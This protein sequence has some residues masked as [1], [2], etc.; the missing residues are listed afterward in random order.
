VSAS[1]GRLAALGFILASCGNDLMEAVSVS[2]DGTESS[3]TSAATTV[4][5]GD[6]GGSTNAGSESAA[7][8]TTE[9]DTT[10][11]SEVG[12]SSSTGGSTTAPESTTTESTGETV[13]CAS[14]EPAECAD[15]PECMVLEGS[16]YVHV[17]GTEYCFEEKT[18]AGCIAEMDCDQGETYGCVG[19]ERWS[20]PTSCLPD[21]WIVCDPPEG[22]PKKCG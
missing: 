21:G 9:N 6:D 19:N 3:S 17:M 4:S 10:G 13:D 20:F 15:A 8:T 7:A 18:F 2:G 14:L 12:G 22:D 16:P 11:T 1:H 5:A